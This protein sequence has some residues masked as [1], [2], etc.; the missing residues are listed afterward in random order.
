MTLKLQIVC[1]GGGS[2]AP[3]PFGFCTFHASDDRVRIIRTIGRR[4]LRAELATVDQ[5]SKSLLASVRQEV[6]RLD[7]QCPRCKRHPKYNQQTLRRIVETI[8]ATGATKWTL[9]VSSYECP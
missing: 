5:E 2:H 6:Q 1:T 8:A 7:D 9:D 3:V 4:G